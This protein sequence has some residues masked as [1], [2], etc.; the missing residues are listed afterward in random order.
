MFEGPYKQGI[1]NKTLCTIAFLTALHAAPALAQHNIEDFIKKEKFIAIKISPT[2]E[3]LA[4]TIPIERKTALAILRRADYKVVASL[5]IPGDRTH[6]ADFWWVNDERVLI[7][8]AQKIGE[9]EQPKLTG[10]LYA[11]NADGS[12]GGILVGQSVKG[13]GP[14]TRI[15]PKKVEEVA[16]FLVDSLPDDDK[17]ALLS[18]TPFSDDP[19]SRIER[20]DVYSGRRVA[21]TQAPVRNAEFVTDNA[22]NVRFAYGQDIDLSRRT[23]Y[24]AAEGSEWRLVGNSGKGGR[25]E[26]PIGFAADNKTAYLL[27]ENERGPNSLVAWDTSSDQKKELLR[28][29]NS[30]PMRIIPDYRGVPMGIAIMDGLPK[31]EFFDAQAPTAKL[32]RKLEQAF[33]GQ[34]VEVTSMTKDGR[35][36]LVSTSSDRNPGDYY[37]FDTTSNKA[38]YLLSSKDWIDPE[39][40][41]SVKPVQFKSRDGLDIHGY[42]TSPVGAEA[43][44]AALIVLIH[45]GPF[46]IFDRWGFD[47]E[48]QM[49]AAHGYAVLQVNFRGS[50]N[51]GA[52]FEEAGR[53]EW[54][55]KMQDDITDATRWA[56]QQGIA[57]PKRICVY[58]ASY[59]AYASLMGVAKE[60]DL[61][62][63]AAG[64]VGVYDLPTM[65]TMGDIQERGSGESYINEWIGPK[66][67]LAAVSPNRIADRIKVP[68]FLAAG[69]EDERAPIQHTELMEKSLKKANVTVE[70]LYYPSE[71][72]GFYKTEN[73]REFY[74]KLLTFFQKHIGG[75]SPR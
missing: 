54:G 61:Y 28:D 65:H 62:R 17:F 69:G 18:I 36:A 40:T 33:S 31:T 8:A 45:G 46:G 12:R 72:H 34:T 2:G 6:V 58:G 35:F 27:V 3:Y 29:D 73:Q 9:L 23:Y 15:Q 16:A 52:A 38:D 30:D 10:D 74:T 53:R 70:S 7:S 11:I 44:N 47:A 57:D 59:G 24:R 71:G 68:V 42:L 41:A 26:Y 49:L 25:F 1:M 48:A 5:S 39:K 13:E 63:C 50:G 32:Y 56:I 66:E 21:V 51:Y 14:G 4:A 37:L 60:P 75:R 19:F 67:S 55:G 20:L 22:G 64:Y 43:K